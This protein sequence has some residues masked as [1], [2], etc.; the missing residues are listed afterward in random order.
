MDQIIFLLIKFKNCL[1]FLLSD[2]KKRIKKLQKNPY[3]QDDFHFI[4]KRNGKTI[5]ILNDS[6]F[7]QE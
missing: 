3:S 4:E 7:Y 6:E 1:K 5:R 2:K